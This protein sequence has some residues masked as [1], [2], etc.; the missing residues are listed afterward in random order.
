MTSPLCSTEDESP[1]LERSVKISI[2]I[3]PRLKREIHAEY[4]D[5]FMWRERGRVNHFVAILTDIACQ[6]QV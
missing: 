2:I 5:K 6:Y 3:Y 4:L 1:V